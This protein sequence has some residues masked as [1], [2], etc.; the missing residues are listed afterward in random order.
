MEEA[1]EEQPF[2]SPCALTLFTYSPLFI[3]SPAD[4][5]CHDIVS[6]LP[7]RYV[8]LTAAYRLLSVTVLGMLALFPSPRPSSSIIPTKVIPR[9]LSE[10]IFSSN[11]RASSS[12]ACCQLQ[13]R[14][15][16]DTLG[17]VWIIQGY[18][19]LPALTLTWGGGSSPSPS[20]CPLCCPLNF[21][22]SSMIKVAGQPRAEGVPP[23]VSHS[24]LCW[25]FAL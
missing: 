8:F 19:V 5:T 25:A 15:P 23:C 1:L 16:A 21:P 18:L 12:A 17:Y 11:P 10:A 4:K 14:W 2:P 6:L 13:T 3:G 24:M 7:G 22:S 9:S 20:H